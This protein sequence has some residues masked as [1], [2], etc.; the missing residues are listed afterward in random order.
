M[1]SNEGDQIYQPIARPKVQEN[2]RRF[3]G[4]TTQAQAPTKARR[5]S[6]HN[7]AATACFP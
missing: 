2:G 7:D 5:S 4:P 3:H 1:G 6:A